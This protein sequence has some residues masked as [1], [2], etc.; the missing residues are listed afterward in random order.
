[1]MHTK[2][3]T[4]ITAKRTVNL[5]RDRPSF[6]SSFPLTL[7][8]FLLLENHFV[9]GLRMKIRC[10][11]ND[12]LHTVPGG[13]VRDNPA[14][15]AESCRE[16]HNLFHP[17]H[18][19]CRSHSPHLWFLSPLHN[20]PVPC[21]SSL[22]PCHNGP[23]RSNFARSDLFRSS[24]HPDGFCRSYSCCLCHSPHRSCSFCRSSRMHVCHSPDYNRSSQATVSKR[25][26]SYCSPY[27]FFYGILCKYKKTVLFFFIFLLVSSF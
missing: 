10:E 25:S 22:F 19:L 4:R 9:K 18:F 21:Y 1:M 5:H 8:C 13:E 12:F 2:C 15:E 26:N 6:H 7:H 14:M 20:S 16:H 23:Y 27:I 17:G 11:P 24:R 3:D